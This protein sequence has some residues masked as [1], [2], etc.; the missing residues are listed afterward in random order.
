[1]K[2]YTVST[3]MLFNTLTGFD[4]EENM[5]HWNMVDIFKRKQM[6]IRSGLI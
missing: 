3:A 2:E 4:N 6:E 1:M 5:Y